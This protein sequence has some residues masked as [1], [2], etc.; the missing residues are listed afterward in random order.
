VELARQRGYT[1]DPLVAKLMTQL[2]TSRIR[3]SAEKIV[4]LTWW[5]TEL[6]WRQC[7]N[8]LALY[9]GARER[10]EQLGYEFEHM[11]AKAPRLTPARLSKILF[12]RAIR[13]VLI[14]PLPPSARPLAPLSLNWRNLACATVGLSVT[15]PDL[16]T[17]AHHH[18]HGVTLAMRK[19]RQHGYRRIGF[20]AR[21]GDLT[22]NNNSWL[23]GFHIYNQSQP[24]C[25]QVAPYLA[26]EKLDIWN[27]SAFAR[28]YEK[29]K[30]DAI[31]STR[32]E[33]LLAMKDLGIRVPQDAGYATLDLAETQISWLTLDTPLA[34]INQKARTLAAAAVDLVDTQL[35]SN[36]SGLPIHPRKVMIEGA[37]QEGGTL[38]RQ[39]RSEA[40]SAAGCDTGIWANG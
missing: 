3:R 33:A 29:E 26:E 15:K 10:A 9:E 31:L 32:V 12:T 5:P 25:H 11:W 27:R 24:P 38:C 40:L 30:P 17:A 2:R 4:Y 19:M 14:A 37:W 39:N 7:T 35:R 21:T 34:G 23:A 36:E 1:P 13:G 22:R 8:D 16:H 28:W 18:Y 20:A 6:G